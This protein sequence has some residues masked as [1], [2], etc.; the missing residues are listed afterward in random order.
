MKALFALLLVLSL[1]ATPALARQIQI[2]DQTTSGYLYPWPN[3]A[4][5]WC[6]PFKNFIMYADDEYLRVG[7]WAL[8]E[9]GNK[10]FMREWSWRVGGPLVWEVKDIRH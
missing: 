6:E 1:L 8:D 3:E 9:A 4:R 7:C 10:L 2:N 5:E